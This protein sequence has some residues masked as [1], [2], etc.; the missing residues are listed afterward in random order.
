MTRQDQKVE[1]G[2]AAI[3]AGGDVVI[4]HGVSPDQMAQIMIAMARQ[5]S[6]FH[7]E[8]LEKANA[9]IDIFQQEILKRFAQPGKANPDAFR[10]PDFQYLLGDAQEAVARSGDAAVRDT[11]VDII[12][13]R[14]LETTRNRLA[15]TLNDAATKA[16]NLTVNEFA[17]LTLVYL[18]RYTIDHSIGSFAALCSYVTNSLLPFVKDVSVEPSSF[19]HLQAQ[20]CGNIEVTQVDLITV[21]RKQYGGV[22]GYGFTREQLEAH[23]PDGKKNALD[24]LVIPAV[25]DASKL[26]PAA[27]NF[28]VLKEKAAGLDLS[29]G[30]LQNVWN[31]FENSMIDVPDRITAA[32]PEARALWKIWVDSPLKHFSLTSVGLAIGHANA[33]RV[34]GLNAP[35]AVWIK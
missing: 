34:I 24:R 32:V 29:E 10:D 9:R 30:E 20:S 1:V 14:S 26:Q 19:W 27:I 3:Q 2:G 11:L 22:L 7:D 18:I 15:I 4:T 12:A 35:L 21:L 17:T 5:L 23:L 33:A 31:V 6:A 13:R 25:H 16:A 28:Q 8:A